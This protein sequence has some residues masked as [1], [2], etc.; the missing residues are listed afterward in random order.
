MSESNEGYRPRGAVLGI[1]LSSSL[2]VIK[3]LFG[4]RLGALSPL[5]VVLLV[6]ALILAL[7][8]LVSPIAPFVYPLF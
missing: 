1:A 8:A 4:A 2:L 6:L 5:V 3:A 7:L